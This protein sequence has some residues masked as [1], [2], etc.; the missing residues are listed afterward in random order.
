MYI[1]YL[2][3]NEIDKVKWD[4]CIDKAY[5]GLIYAYSWYLDIVSENWEAL[6]D[7]DYSIVFPLTAR[8]KLNIHYLYPPFFTQQ[9]G[10]FAINPLH[11]DITLEFIN[12]IPPKYRFVEINLN[13][14]NNVDKG[15]FRFFTNTTFELDL[16]HDYQQLYDNFS[17][18]TRRNIK[19]STLYNVRIVK[20]IPPE[21]II[22][23]F[24]KNKGREVKT[25]KKK[26]YKTLLRLIN[27][28]IKRKKAE[29]WSAY[30][31]KDKLCAGVFFIQSHN[32]AI[33][34]FSG[35]NA[36]ARENA[37]MTHIINRFIYE[38]AGKNLVLDFAGS[39]NRSLARFYKGFGSKEC[40]Y[41]LLKINKLPWYYRVFKK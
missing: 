11:E 22:T 6:T 1:R 24:R 25:L 39:N 20:N 21:N 4:A 5:N 31:T 10:I 40:K 7:D 14:F 41:Q 15:N 28:L 26:D 3:H 9:L 23:L 32:K 30:N 33:F 2:K 8:S 12:A 13:K 27:E 17:N 38:N 36:I 35:R 16:I 37:A 19:K 34:L 29:V 18:N